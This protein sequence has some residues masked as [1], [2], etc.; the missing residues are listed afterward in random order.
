MTSRDEIRLSPDL[1]TIYRAE[2]ASLG[3]SPGRLIGADIHRFR[4]MADAAIPTLTQQEW[5]LLAHVCDG[6]EALDIGVSQIDDLPSGNRIAAEI[7]DW[8]RGASSESK[9]G[10]AVALYDQAQQ[11]PPL[12]VAGVLMRLRTDGAKAADLEGGE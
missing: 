10:W 2:A 1:L 8:M 7:M 3:T 11:W 12:T 9:P 5:G 4:R 6:I